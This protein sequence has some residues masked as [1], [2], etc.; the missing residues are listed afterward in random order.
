MKNIIIKIKPLLFFFSTFA[1][2]RISSFF[3]LPICTFALLCTFAYFP[4]KTFAQDSSRIRISLLTCT[5][6]DELYS[7]FG[8][9]ALR[10]I[11]SNSVTDIVYNY[12]TFNFDDEGFYVKFARGKLK[13]YI[14]ITSFED[15]KYDYQVTNRGITEQVLQFSEPEKINIQHALIENLKEENKYY[16]YDFF[17]DNCTTRLRDLIVKS[18]QP[19]PLLPSVKPVDMRFR[20]AIHE[21]LHRGHQPW[22][23]LGIDIL[24]GAPTDRIMTAAEQ[25]FLPDNLMMALDSAKNSSVVASAQN[26]YPIYSTAIKKGFFTPMVFFVSLL[27]VFI[28]LHFILKNKLPVMLAGLDGLLFFCTGLLGFVLVFMSTATDHSMTKNNYN[29]LW[30]LPTH[31]VIS[32][33]INSKKNLVKKYFGF[34]AIAGLLLL[35]CWFFLPQQMNNALIPFV[36]ILIFRAVVRYFK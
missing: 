31:L 12:G 18:K 32:F 2:L 20:Q 30:A 8:H 9:S 19:A 15:F 7:I 14:S 26:L 23:K 22:S 29:L 27:A 13:Y 21:Y 11:D 36:L 33:F 28:L 16:Q 10:V 1:H 4:V 34:T 35:G 17:F 24:L 3:R 6:G 5:P 25:Q